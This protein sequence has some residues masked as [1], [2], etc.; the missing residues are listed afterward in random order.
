MVRGR[1][2]APMSSLRQ[3]SGLEPHSTV[4]LLAKFRG[5]STSCPRKTAA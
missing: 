1:K 2:R 4:T 3:V 5:L